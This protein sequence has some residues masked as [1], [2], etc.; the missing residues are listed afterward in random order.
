MVMPA[1]D[2]KPI[3]CQN[4][5]DMNKPD[6]PSPQ[7]EA[8]NGPKLIDAESEADFRFALAALLPEPGPPTP[9]PES[10]Q[11]A[12]APA[13]VLN[14]PTHAQNPPAHAESPPAHL[15]SPGDFGYDEQAVFSPERM[16]R[17]NVSAAG[18]S[19]VIPAVSPTPPQGQA[20]RPAAVRPDPLPPLPPRST[21]TPLDAARPAT[22]PPALP[23]NPGSPPA[24]VRPVPLPYL[25]ARR[26]AIPFEPEGVILEPSPAPQTSPAP[27][28]AVRPEPLPRNPSFP[29]A[30]PFEVALPVVAPPAALQAVP[31]TPVADRPWPVLSAPPQ[32][33]ATPLQATLAEFM[34]RV[35]APDQP[36]QP[37]VARA[38]SVPPLPPIPPATPLEVPWAVAATTAAPQPANVRTEPT[39]PLPSPLPRTSL[40]AALSEINSPAVPQIPAVPPVAVQPKPAPPQPAPS[41][42]DTPP[43]VPPVAAPVALAPVVVAPI[44]GPE[45][46]ASDS[47]DIPLGEFLHLTPTR[48]VSSAAAA[49]ASHVQAVKPD[50]AH[51][52]ASPLMPGSK[53]SPE[54]PGAFAFPAA[55]EMPE[56]AT[57]AQGPFSGPVLP[58]QEL[59]LDLWD[60]ELKPGWLERWTKGWRLALIIMLLLAG[61]VTWRGRRD[62]DSF[63][64]WRAERLASEALE[65]ATLDPEAAQA[66]LDQ[67]AILAPRNPVVLRAMVDF[68]ESRGDRMALFALRQLII[69]NGAE[70]ADWER[71]CR[72]AQEWGHPELLPVPLVSA[73]ANLPEKSLNH[74]QTMVVCRWLASRGMMEDA[75]KRLREAISRDHAADLELALASV[76]LNLAG[77][78]QGEARGA[79]AIRL[80]ETL[81]Q[82]SAAPL[83]VRSDA[84]RLLANIML[85]K[86]NRP[87]LTEAR[88]LALSAAFEKLAVE[89]PPAEALRNQLAAVSLE[90]AAHEDRKAGIIRSIAGKATAASGAD[91]LLYARWLIDNAACEEALTL[92]S[93]TPAAGRDRDWFN[94]KLDAL[95]GLSRLGDAAKILQ[96]E[97]QPLPPV[98]KMIFLYRIAGAQGVNAAELKKQRLAVLDAAGEPAD[99]LK[100]AEVLEK[101]LDLETAEAL[102]RRIESDDRNGLPARLGIVRCLDAAPERTAEL[103]VALEAVLRLWPHLD[104]ARSNLTYLKLLEGTATPAEIEIVA[105]LNRRAPRFLAYRVPAALA[106]LKSENAAAALT[107]LEA[108]AAP[109]RQVRAGWQAVYAA[110]L[111]ANGRKDEARTIKER[112]QGQPLRPHEKKLLDR[113]LVTEP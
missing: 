57:S 36:A 17:A 29:P 16:V 7:G 24:A 31:S 96:A 101:A 10:A 8:F 100:A 63:K 72:L 5:T 81:S 109:W 60:P 70:S 15:Q 89:S 82:S 4:E 71:L 62:Y 53:D 27:P 45:F 13:H 107:L 66:L 76:L 50:A 55:E 84:L 37:T 32:P 75:E 85:N 35:V 2:Q 23:Q 1:V 52:I 92:H 21:E 22:L 11:P 106:E 26:P 108:D 58:P 54:D 90:L 20:E 48:P 33:G 68:C 14:P 98:Q 18:F 86:A 44:I 38:E 97:D 43:T 110:G 51:S 56:A 74:V 103:I 80:L 47:E 40:V 83:T 41:V 99:I 102:Y 61:Y 19:G 79:E 69:Y 105:E 94:V 91:R 30:T 3:L 67:A 73:W 39:T 28:S 9:D 59:S 6:H 112:L 42:A 78:P 104:D 49:S 95:F 113:Y 87:L 25:P 34:P 65:K 77:G 64:Q 88:A 46:W 12:G 111:A 93:Q